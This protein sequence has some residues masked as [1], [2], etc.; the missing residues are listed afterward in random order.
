MLAPSAACLSFLPQLY[1]D[2]TQAAAHRGFA[3]AVGGAQAQ[4]GQG[5]ADN[6]GSTVWKKRALDYKCQA[7]HV[8]DAQQSFS[9]FKVFLSSYNLCVVIELNN[10]F[11]FRWFQQMLVRAQLG[12]QGSDT[13]SLEPTR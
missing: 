11:W 3:C 8:Q 5:R 9:C 1:P 12:R 2:T 7:A 6:L 13:P 10:T 4:Q